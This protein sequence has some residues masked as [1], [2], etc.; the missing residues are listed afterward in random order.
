[1]RKGTG[2]GAICADCCPRVWVGR[3]VREGVYTFRES[4]MVD[5]VVSQTYRML[6]DLRGDGEVGP[7][8]FYADS[9]EATDFAD[10]YTFCMVVSFDDAQWRLADNG[11]GDVLVTTSKEI[12]ERGRSPHDDDNQKDMRVLRRS[13]VWRFKQEGGALR[14]T[15]NADADAKVNYD[16]E[17]IVKFVDKVAE[18][19]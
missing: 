18:R 2:S 8:S 14:F 16:D 4:Y 10:N 17:H 5:D 1:M 6:V 9:S 11:S 3:M 15:G 13:K 7:F 12:Q 19:S